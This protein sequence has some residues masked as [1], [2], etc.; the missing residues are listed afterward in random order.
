MAGQKFD[1]LPDVTT[2]ERDLRFQL[3]D[4]SSLATLSSAQVTQFNERGYIAP[5]RVFDEE[6]I[7]GI[8][9]YF[10]TLLERVIASG[11][12]SYSI[13]S[14]HLEH[15]YVYDIL[16]NT[17]IVAL[18]KDLLGENI[19]G[20]G[21]HFFCKMPGD[22]KAV[23]WHQDASYWPLTPS[24]TVTVWVAID[25]A[26][27]GNAC[28][29]FLTGSHHHGHLTWRPSTPEEHNVLNQTVEDAEQYGDPVD[30]VLKAGEASI[31]SDL[32]LHGS[33]ANQSDRRRCGLTLRYAPVEVRA[34]QGW[35]AKGVVLSG[36]D[37]DGHWGN[38]TRP[39]QD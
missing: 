24:R 13:S 4:N 21:S 23:A 12:N 27:R 14:A 26:D 28:M 2:E 1:I 3:V 7:I 39:K 15:G 31:H 18:V 5:V 17:R 10:D 16:S 37:P 6:Q 35:N 32:L 8:R 11:G 36:T 33:N 9:D 30:N 34:G 22:G 25:D 29:R 19:V 38:P 20:W